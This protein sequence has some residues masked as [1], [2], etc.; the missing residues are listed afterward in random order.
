[1]RHIFIRVQL[2][3]VSVVLFLTFAMTLSLMNRFNRRMDFTK[4]KL[5]SLDPS[6]LQILEQMKTGSLEALAFYPQ[7]DPARAN[8]EVFLKEI[9]LHHAGFNYTFYDPDRVPSLAKQYQIENFYTVILRYDGRQ[10][11]VSSPTEESMTNALLRLAKPKQIGVC[12]VTGHAE[13]VLGNKER[14]GLAL[15]K[16]NLENK[17]YSIHEIILARD[18][19]PPFCTVT[20]IPGPHRDFDLEEFEILKKG[21]EQGSGILMLID[22][23]DPG[24]GKSFVNFFKE[25]GFLLGEDVIVDKMSRVVGGD[26]LVPLISQ[27]VLKH[28][29]T[30]GF[31]KPTFLPVT[32]S[33]QPSLD[34]K[35][36]EVVPLALSSSGSWAETNLAQL[37]KARPLLNRKAIWPGLFLSRPR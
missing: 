18:R 29:I 12:F 3:V 28:P 36:F 32:R 20:V 11:R 21:F 24:A 33:I 31:E 19:V 10:E 34:V 2:I 16:L 5:Y 35:E 17:N 37:E 4:E 26:F 30:A 14:P 13:A 8:F 22:P 25:F 27:Y 15:L 9:R 1:M 23:M 6:T 7:D